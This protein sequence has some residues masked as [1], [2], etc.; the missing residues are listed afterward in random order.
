MENSH[1]AV[2]YGATGGEGGVYSKNPKATAA[3]NIIGYSYGQA[4]C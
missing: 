1:A 4:Q 2:G 3:L